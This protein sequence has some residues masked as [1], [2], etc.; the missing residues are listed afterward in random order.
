M[1]Y[2]GYKR[3]PYGSIYATRRRRRYARSIRGY[4]RSTMR[5]KSYFRKRKFARRRT[6]SRKRLYTKNHKNDY[7]NVRFLKSY[8]NYIATNVIGIPTEGNPQ[9]TGGCLAFVT[10]QSLTTTLSNLIGVYNQPVG[11]TINGAAMVSSFSHLSQLYRHVRISRVTVY[12]RWNMPIPVAG[13]NSFAA[14]GTGGNTT[15]TVPQPGFSRDQ[16]ADATYQPQDALGLGINGKSAVNNSNP[17]T[18]ASYFPS[19]S[20]NGMCC[21]YYPGMTDSAFT[22]PNSDAEWL[23]WNGIK[24]YRI[25][26]PFKIVAIPKIRNPVFTDPIAAGSLITGTLRRMPWFNPQVGSFASVQLYM[27][28]IRTI[29]NF[30]PHLQLLTTWVVHW[31][32]RDRLAQ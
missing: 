20:R 30:N 26:K 23:N 14:F 22:I 5:A 1:A 31:K 2:F 11:S 24:R 16:D 6:F 19:M 25:G 4:S 8:P 29:G 18:F 9:P 12:C 27:P 13:V 17:G 15:A 3:K 21:V 28:T 7:C 32:F 10:G